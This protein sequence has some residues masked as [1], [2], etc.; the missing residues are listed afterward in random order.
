MFKVLKELSNR[1]KMKYLLQG[2]GSISKNK[3][4]RQNN[5]TLTQRIGTEF[6]RI[7]RA[8]VTKAKSRTIAS[9]VKGSQKKK[10]FV[11]FR[12]LKDRE[13]QMYVISVFH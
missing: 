12:P 3:I 8:R 11:D 10:S 1:F 6:S 9:F 2:N 4:S 5:C 7:L 13:H